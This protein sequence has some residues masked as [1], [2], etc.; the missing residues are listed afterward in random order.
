MYN[1]I[2]WSDDATLRTGDLSN[3]SK[4]VRERVTGISGANAAGR[5]TGGDREPKGERLP[6]VGGTA[7]ARESSAEKLHGAAALYSASSLPTIPAHLPSGD[8]PES[9]GRTRT[10]PGAPTSLT[11]D[12]V[13]GPL[14]SRLPLPAPAGPPSLLSWGRC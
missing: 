2:F 12:W 7:G 14:S 13:P 1:E 6:S 3:T 11:S 10:S 4:A 5:G 9:G 8:W